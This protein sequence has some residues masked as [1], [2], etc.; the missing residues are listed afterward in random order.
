MEKVLANIPRN[1]CVVYLFNLLVDA[2]TL[3]NQRNVF[4]TITRISP[5]PARDVLPRPEV[6][7]CHPVGLTLPPRP[8][9]AHHIKD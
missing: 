8:H 5:V 3:A 1:C 9:L 7:D 2:G 4:Q 6:G